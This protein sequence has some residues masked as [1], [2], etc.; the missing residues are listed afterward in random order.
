MLPQ[1]PRVRLHAKASW[2]NAR[3]NAGCGLTLHPWITVG[4][5]DM[6]ATLLRRW[7]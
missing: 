6:V 2:T 1:L 4:K 3:S 7:L 5:A